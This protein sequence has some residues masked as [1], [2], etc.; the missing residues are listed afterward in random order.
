[1][2][3]NSDAT[4]NTRSRVT[5]ATLTTIVLALI[6]LCGMKTPIVLMDTRL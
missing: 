5:M 4:K 3:R 1:M 6:S 2:R